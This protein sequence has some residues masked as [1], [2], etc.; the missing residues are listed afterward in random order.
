MTVQW[1]VTEV[2][3]TAEQKCLPIRSKTKLTNGDSGMK[4]RIVNK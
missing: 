1:S 3:A 2:V 4:M